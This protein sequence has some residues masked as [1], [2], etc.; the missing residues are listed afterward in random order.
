MKKRMFLLS[1]CLLLTACASP[2]ASVEEVAPPTCAETPVETEATCG[3]GIPYRM[4]CRIVDGAESGSLILAEQGDTGSGVYTLSITALAP[5]VPPDEPLRNGQ[6]IDVYYGAFTESWP[7]GF[8]GVTAIEIVK[9][10]FDNRCS[11]YLKVLEDLWDA[12]PALSEGVEFVG[13]DLTQTSLSPAEQAAVGWVFAG[14]HG[15]DTVEGTV[16]ELVEQGWISATPLSISGSGTDLSQTE[17]YFYEWKNGCHF[18]IAE[19]PMEGTYSLVP[20]TFDA[21][22]WRSSLGAYMFCDCTA[23]QSAPGEWSDYQIGSEAVS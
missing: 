9:G 16:E 4:T 18:S 5:G 21:M 10:S 17:H 13:I 8:G 12:D 23:V 15:A 2:S 7:M 14:R 19:Q 11:L 1:L 6:L 3:P 20:V 22:K